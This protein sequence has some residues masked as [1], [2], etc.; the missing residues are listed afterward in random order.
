MRLPVHPKAA[1]KKMTTVRAFQAKTD[2]TE[3][4]LVEAVA[5]SSKSAAAGVVKVR[6]YAERR[7]DMP[8]DS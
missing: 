6:K 4:E 3:Q 7:G 1:A 5:Q 2:L 8:E